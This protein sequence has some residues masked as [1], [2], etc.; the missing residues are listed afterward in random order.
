[1]SR[2]NGNRSRDHGGEQAGGM[3]YRDRENGWIFGV[4]AGLADYAG[5]QPA[6][7]RLAALLAL[8]LFFWYAVISY[9]AAALLLRPKPLIWSGRCPEYDFWRRHRTRGR[10]SHT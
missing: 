4:C 8:W 9:L 10:W 5:V 2:T 6:A 1:M 3:L 7:V